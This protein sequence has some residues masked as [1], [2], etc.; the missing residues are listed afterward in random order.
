MD[1]TLKRKATRK[2]MRIEKNLMENPNW[3]RSPRTRKNEERLPLPLVIRTATR[4]LS[5]I[6]VEARRVDAI[7][8]F[9]RVWTASTPFLGTSCTNRTITHNQ[10]WSKI[11]NSKEMN[12]LNNN[13]LGIAWQIITMLQLEQ[14]L[15]H[16]L[17]PEAAVDGVHTDDSLL[18]VF[19]KPVEEPQVISHHHAQAKR[20]ERVI[21]KLIFHGC[22]TRSRR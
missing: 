9:L 7:M 22:W 21:K 12:P 19:H 2:Q 20:H 11:I 16:G 4:E 5:V 18:R 10:Y 8:L 1:C 6:A 17:N 3:L 15:H 13:Y 14:D